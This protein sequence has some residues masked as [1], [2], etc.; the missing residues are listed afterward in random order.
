M[1]RLALLAGAAVAAIG[2]GAVGAASLDPEH[3]SHPLSSPCRITVKAHEDGSASLYCEGEAVAF[4]A[5]DAESGRVR[6]S[7]R[8]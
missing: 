6:I 3:P 4:G 8:P 2:L 7:A 5:I 1:K